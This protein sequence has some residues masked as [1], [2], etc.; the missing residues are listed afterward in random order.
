[1]Y[2]CWFLFLLPPGATSASPCLSK[3]SLE[4]IAD[5]STSSPREGSSDKETENVQVVRENGDPFLGE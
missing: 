3:N 5:S 4:G 2:P 1:M